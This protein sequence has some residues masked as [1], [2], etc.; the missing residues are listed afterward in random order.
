MELYQNKSSGKYFILI[1]ETPDGKLLLVTPSAEIKQLSP[2]LFGAVQELEAE[3]LL[4]R[5]L[6]SSEQIDRYNKFIENESFEVRSSEID[7][8]TDK[9]ETA[10]KPSKKMSTRQ[11]HHETDVVIKRIKGGKGK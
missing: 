11:N 10:K 7:T 4:S 2:T 1:E 6:I 8:E 5:N 3:D 9:P